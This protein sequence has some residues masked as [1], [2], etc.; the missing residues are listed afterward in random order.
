M[1]F[2]ISANTDDVFWEDSIIANTVKSQLMNDFDDWTLELKKNADCWLYITAV[3]SF[4]V[5]IAR[6]SQMY[7]STHDAVQ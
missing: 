6:E 1:N 2:V 5:E 3:F 4:S 7:I